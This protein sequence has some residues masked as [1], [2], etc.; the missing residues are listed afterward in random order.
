MSKKT[1]SLAQEILFS[2]S[3][4][5]EES[6]DFTQSPP[7][8]STSVSEANSAEICP[9]CA[10]PL[11]HCSIVQR[12]QHINDCLDSAASRATLT[13]Q[14]EHWNRTIDCPLCN[15]PLDFGPFRQAHLKRCGK[16]HDVP[17][18]ELLRLVQI[19]ERIAETRKQHGLP[20]T[21]LKKPSISSARREIACRENDVPKSVFDEQVRLAQALS[22]SLAEEGA[23]GMES[24]VISK[25]L[26]QTRLPTKLEMSSPKT[27]LALLE[28][29][30]SDLLVH[31]LSCC[32]EQ[33]RIS[34]PK[35]RWP[36]FELDG[37][38]YSAP[39]VALDADCEDAASPERAEPNNELEVLQSQRI[40]LLLADMHSL[41][42]SEV[43]TDVEIFCGPTFEMCKAHSVILKSRCPS[44]LKSAS[45]RAGGRYDL[46]VPDVTLECMRCFLRYLYFADEEFF[47]SLSFDS[48]IEVLQRFPPSGW[49]PMAIGGLTEQ[50]S[51]DVPSLCAKNDDASMVDLESQHSDCTILDRQADTNS[52]PE[53]VVVDIDLTA[54]EPEKGV[55][56]DT[57]MPVLTSGSSADEAD[58]PCTSNK[59][60]SGYSTSCK[61]QEYPDVHKRE[62]MPSPSSTTPADEQLN[63]DRSTESFVCLETVSVG[64]SAG[65]LLEQVSFTATDD[66]AISPAACYSQLSPEVSLHVYEEISST[67]TP[68]QTV[69]KGICKERPHQTSVLSA[70]KFSRSSPSARMSRKLLKNALLKTPTMRKL[71]QQGLMVVKTQSV[72]PSVDLSRMTTPQLQNKLRRYG[73]RALPKRRAITVLQRI[74]NETHP[75]VYQDGTVEFPL[76]EDPKIPR[77]RRIEG[78]SDKGSVRK[79]CRNYDA[80][81][82]PLLHPL[83]EGR[84]SLEES[85]LP[86]VPASNSPEKKAIICDDEN[87][88]DLLTSNTDI[89]ED[90]LTYTPLNL[91]NVHQRLKQAGARCSLRGLLNY[92]DTQCITFSM[93]KFDECQ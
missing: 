24:T 69:R 3:F 41:L 63:Q 8:S 66:R 49:N 17:P 53:E 5:L 89:Y 39:Q 19:Q 27:R 87:L 83:S 51:R 70:T 14:R 71:K 25:S 36:S 60:E 13:R 54:D 33:K 73:V 34:N 74:Y 48:A 75:Y 64:S 47:S 28:G 26:T 30:L 79:T 55:E 21:R 81:G 1:V 20:H 92:L 32:N 59:I 56:K 82:V 88:R 40:E 76:V 38:V 50:S 52:G 93:K 6:G 43:G 91:K 57:Q 85:F 58:Y 16:A 90:I 67:G 29:R 9:A 78:L 42:N 68:Q 72:T 61:V 11:T 37:P 62:Y 80:P 31:R 84:K 4:R 15:Q 44:L 65:A 45:K 35:Y 86:K 2:G 10:K 7:N 46:F 77:K 12:Q 23:V 18:G 22:R